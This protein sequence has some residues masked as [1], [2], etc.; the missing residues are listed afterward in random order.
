MNLHERHRPRF[1]VA[2]RR[3]MGMWACVALFWVVVGVIWWAVRR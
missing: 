3:A 1:T 2:Q